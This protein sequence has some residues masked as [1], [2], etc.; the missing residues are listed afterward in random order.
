MREAA[1][2][3]QWNATAARENCTRFQGLPEK[4]QSKDNNIRLP[5]IV[6]PKIRA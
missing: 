4:S 1:T 6:T 3:V 2:A 5:Y